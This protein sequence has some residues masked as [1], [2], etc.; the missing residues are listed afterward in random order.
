MGENEA[1]IEMVGNGKRYETISQNA[2]FLAYGRQYGGRK[3]FIKPRR[4]FPN[5]ITV[6]RQNDS[7]WFIWTDRP[8]SFCYRQA[9]QLNVSGLLVPASQFITGANKL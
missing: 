8:T 5:P 4:P 2:I 3:G 1:S 6:G 9:G 7:L